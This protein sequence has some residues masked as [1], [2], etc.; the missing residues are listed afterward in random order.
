MLSFVDQAK[1]ELEIRK[2][3]FRRI[4]VPNA[5][6]QND[7]LYSPAFEILYGGQAGGGKTSLLVNLAKLHHHRSLLI[8]RTY[9]QL[10]DSII[11]ES[12]KWYG[13]RKYY[14]SSKHYWEWPSGQ[15]IRIG[16]C[17]HDK[18]MLDYQGAEFDLLAVDELTQMNRVPYEYL[19][20]RVRSTRKGQR[21]RVMCTSN[22]GGDGHAWVKERWAPW[23][24]DKH[25]NPAAPGELRWYKRRSDDFWV[26]TTPDD[27]DAKSRTFIPARLEDN[28]YLWEDDEYRKTLNL[29][30]EP[31]RSQLLN[32]D[33]SAGEQDDVYQVIPTAWVRA[34]QARWTPEVYGPLDAVGVDIAHGGDDRTVIAFRHGP[35]VSRIDKYP[36]RVTPD[37]Q[38]AVA[39][40]GVALSEGGWAYIDAM[41]PSALDIASGMGMR[42]T[43]VNFGSGSDARDKSGQFGF[44]NLRAEMYWRTREMLAPEAEVPVALPPD[45]E[46]LQ[47]LTAP[48]WSVQLNGIKIESKDAITSRLGRSPDVADAVVLA[49]WGGGG[50]W[51]NVSFEIVTIGA[52]R[53]VPR[54]Q[55][56]SN[57]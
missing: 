51:N 4:W 19:I 11:P 18:N 48:R 53:D 10:E 35:V 7:V 27:P 31:Y 36:G 45:P 25:P 21:T 13:D 47:E 28:P 26:E 14:N 2:R 49:L 12:I 41:P 29:L 56:Y 5:G 32:G 52:R 50:V 34:A 39:L 22:P 9:P 55:K 17:E 37:G 1:I 8:R 6:P 33:W 23:L 43:G 40:L 38:S 15:R 20:S 57:F 54:R 24:D 46:L 30:P 42:V 16:H 3:G 44:T